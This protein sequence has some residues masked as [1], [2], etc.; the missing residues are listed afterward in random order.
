MTEYL[1]FTLSK[2]TFK[3]AT[4]R[5]YSTEGLWAK[6]DGNRVTVGLSDFFQ[7]R[8]GDVAF[9]EAGAVGAAVTAGAEFAA[10]E[11]I[12]V[13]IALTSPLSGTIVAVN[14]ALEW[15]AEIINQAP[16]DR[17]WLVVIEAS[18]WSADQ[19]QLLTPAAYFEQM[20]GEAAA[21]VG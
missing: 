9:A 6:A 2:F 16:Y 19:A 11:T 4:D 17:G 12:K 21:E 3:V 14:P 20:K 1:Q 10:I 8:S 13:N 7:Q 5:L 18:D 15:E